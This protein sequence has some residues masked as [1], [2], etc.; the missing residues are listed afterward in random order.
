VAIPPTV[1][2][3][4]FYRGDL[5][6]RVASQRSQAQAEAD[7]QDHD[8]GASFGQVK[9][10]S[11]LAVDAINRAI[12]D[13][14]VGLSVQRHANR[15]AGRGVISDDWNAGNRLAPRPLSYGLKALLSESGVAQSYCFPIRHPAN[16]RLSFSNPSAKK[17]PPQPV[18]LR[19]PRFR[20]EHPGERNSKLGVRA[21]S[22]WIRAQQVV[23]AAGRTSIFGAVDILC[24]CCG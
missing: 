16:V 13:F 15:K 10:S 21:M 9:M 18:S 7:L 11:L 20:E 3:D 2:A 23:M 17:R 5:F 4:T 24:I 19:R 6:L 14:L 22:L 1:P 8:D 12:G